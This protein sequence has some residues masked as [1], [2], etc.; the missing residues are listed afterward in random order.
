MLSLISHFYCTFV[1]DDVNGTRLAFRLPSSKKLERHFLKTNTVR[2]LYAFI[3]SEEDTQGKLFDIFTSYPV[4]SLINKKDLSVE[5]AG[6]L[7]SQVT[8]RFK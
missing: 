4:V 7:N 6:L 8:V 3:A 5:A 1:A 2:C